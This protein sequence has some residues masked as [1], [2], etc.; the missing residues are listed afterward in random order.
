VVGLEQSLAAKVSRS[1][2]DL[3]FIRDA[4]VL[5]HCAPRMQGD[6]RTDFLVPFAYDTSFNTA[7]SLW[8]YQPISVSAVVQVRSMIIG[9]SFVPG[10]LRLLFSPHKALIT[11][12][13]LGP[14]LNGAWNG[15]L[16]RLQS[17]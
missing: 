14:S 1:G 8:R 9:T 10:I 11:L 15:W 2:M 7:Y 17:L 4:W 6:P 3:H 16:A 12:K 13:H 5:H